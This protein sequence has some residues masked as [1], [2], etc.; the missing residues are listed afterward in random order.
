MGRGN[1]QETEREICSENTRAMH[2]ETYGEMH[3]E[4]P[5][6]SYKDTWRKV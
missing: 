6:K 1:T 5:Q 2:N 3:R 4:N